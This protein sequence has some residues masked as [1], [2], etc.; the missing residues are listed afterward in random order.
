M[1][2]VTLAWR[3][4]KTLL[5]RREMVDAT[6]WFQ[7]TPARVDGDH[8]FAL[9]TIGFVDILGFKRVWKR[10]SPHDVIAFLQQ[11]RDSINAVQ[12][13]LQEHMDL[14]TGGTWQHRAIF[15]SDTIGIASFVQLPEKTLNNP[16]QILA[17]T[18]RPVVTACFGIVANC[19]SGTIPLAFRGCISSGHLLVEDQF[20]IGPA[21]D[22]AGTW[23]ETAEAGVVWL[24]P[25]TASLWSNYSSND[26]LLVKSKIPIHHTRTRE[27]GELETL[28]VNPLTQPPSAANLSPQQRWMLVQRVYDGYLEAMKGESESI[29]RKRENTIR[30]LDHCRSQIPNIEQP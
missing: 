15:M 18:V 1:C 11:A 8:P 25:G 20:V 10:Y 29:T 6:P 16:D 22:V 23:M 3:R 27:I 26:S 9:G 14:Q 2:G 19:V 17:S 5:G 21:V 30:F 12:T 13:Q 4:L 7:P 28:V 24:L